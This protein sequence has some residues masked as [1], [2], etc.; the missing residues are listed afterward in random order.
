M[1]TSDD[2]REG[3]EVRIIGNSTS[4]GFLNGA[5]V[6]VT[7]HWSGS[8]VSC[9][10]TSKTYRTTFWVNPEDVELIIINYNSVKYKKKRV[11]IESDTFL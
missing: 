2:L 5:V 4:H 10:G 1:I 7:R 3:L 11:R 6:S 8:H 9:V